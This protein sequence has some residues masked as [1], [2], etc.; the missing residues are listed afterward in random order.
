MSITEAIEEIAALLSAGCATDKA[1]E[2]VS[3]DFAL[4][5]LLL[6]RKFFEK[7]GVAPEDY[8]A[9]A[10]RHMRDQNLAS[11]KARSWATQGVWGEAVVAPGTIFKA[12][13]KTWA[14]VGLRREEFGS[15]VIAIEVGKVRD[16][17]VD[18]VLWQGCVPCLRG[19]TFQDA[20]EVIINSVVA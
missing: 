9:P 12:C 17:S 4:N 5:P 6:K 18:E 20:A 19:L 3:A 15:D 8:A 7:Y 2:E 13:G 11:A 10:P 16:P 14:F 1:V